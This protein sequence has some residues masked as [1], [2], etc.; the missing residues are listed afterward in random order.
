MK[1]L[2]ILG[3]VLGSFIL[4][5]CSDDDKYN[6]ASGV[7]VEMGS[8]EITVSES[9]GNLKVPVKITGDANGPVKVQLKIESTG[10]NPALPYEERNGEWNGH[11][12]LTSDYLNVPAKEKIAYIDVKLFDD[13]DE[14]ENRTFTISIVSA[15]GAEIGAVSSTLVTI[16]DN[17]SDPYG[18]TQGEWTFDCMNFFDEVPES[19]PVYITGVPESDPNFGSVLYVAGLAALPTLE[20]VALYSYDEDTKTGTLTFKL[21]QLIG[22][23]DVYDIALFT[24]DGKYITPEGEIVA[25]INP[26]FN[27]I[28]FDP[29]DIFYFAA[30]QGG[31]YA[32]GLDGCYEMSMKR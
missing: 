31:Q 14:N 8:S 10:N 26:E 2:K 21:G 3:L 20:A 12:L 23:Y 19:Y 15:E 13:R 16:K 28:T 32:G 4:A 9:A 11:F 17:D 29:N 5:A 18:K 27:A 1:Y 6:T 25:T 30:Y 24:V 7:T 22:T